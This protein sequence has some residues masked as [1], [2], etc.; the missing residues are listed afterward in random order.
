MMQSY[1]EIMS[2]QREQE[3]ILLQ[4]QAVEEKQELLAEEQAANPSEPS[5]V[6]YFYNADYDNIS[7][8]STTYTIHLTKNEVKRIQHILK[9]TWFD[10]ITPDFL[11]TDSLSM[12]D[13]HLSTI[14]ETESDELIKSS[15]EN[16][17][18]T[19]SESEDLSKDLSDIE[20]ECNVPVC[21]DFTTVSNPL[22]DVDNDFSSSDDKSFSDEDVPKENFKNF[23]NPLSDEEIISTKIDP[24]HF[25]AESDLIESLLNRDTLIISSPKFDSLLEEFSGELA[26]IDLIPPRINEADFDPEEDIH[27]VN[28]LL[29]DNSSPRPPKEFNYEYSDAIIE[30][31]SP[32]PIPVEDSDS[33]MEKI[34]LFLT[35]DDSMPSGIE[36]D[37][38]ESEGDILFLEEL[39]SNDSPSLPENESFHFDVPS[40]PRPPARPP[41]EPPDVEICFDFKPDA[42]VV[43]NKV[44]GDISEYYVLMPNLLP[45][46][47]TLCPVFDLLLLFSSENEDKVFN[48]GR[49]GKIEEEVYVCQPP[50]FEDPDF[51]NKVYKVEK[52]LYG[53]HQA[54]KAWY[55]TLS[56]YLLG[57]GFQRGKIDK[58]LFIRRDKGDILLVQ[59]YVD[60]II[61]GSTKKSL[62]IE[63][64][65]MMHKKFQM[66]STVEL[67]FFLRLQVKQKEDVIFISQDKYVTE[68]LKKFG[69]TD[70]KT[71]S[72]P[73]ETQKALLKD[74]DGE[75]VD[76]HLY[77][78]MI[79]SLMYLTSSRP[80]IMFAVCACA[81]YQVNPKVSH[82]HAVKR[83]F[84]YLK[85]QPKLG[86]WYP[87]DSPFDLVAYTHSD[88][89]RA[90]LDR[91]F[92]TGCCQSLGCRL[93]SWQC[94]KQTVVFNSTTE[95]EYVVASSCC[96]QVLWIQNQLLDYSSKTTAWNEFSSTMASAIIC[97]ATNQKFN[98]LKYIFDNMVK[99]L[100]NVSSKFLMYLRFVQV[101][102]DKQLEG[103]QSHKRIYDA[104]SHTKKI[105]GNMKM[106]KKKKGEGSANPTDPHHTPTIIQPSTSQPQKKQRS[107]RLKRKDTKV[108]QLSGPITN[109]A[110]EAV[111]EEMDD[112]WGERR[113][114]PTREVAD[115]DADVGINYESCCKVPVKPVS[116]ATTTTTVITNDEITLAKALAELKSAKL[117]TTTAATIITTEHKTQ[118]KKACKATAEEEEEEEERLAREKAQQIKEVNIVWDDV[119]ARVKA[120]NQLAKDLQR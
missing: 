25:N 5:P 54:P 27:L 99:N 33:L 104:P 22:F 56:T 91:K 109:V 19:P 87:K 63:F 117:P 44:V 66:S 49:N 106:L 62:C 47:P 40:S 35:L 93:I 3:A 29:Y 8:P 16:L 57:N 1:C 113:M 34:D 110:D 88:Y 107:R 11:I 103:M 84:R 15:V 51:P 105:F 18:P 10:V 92:I 21:D 32:S 65:K 75:E 55:E 86:L 114:H 60:D 6:S 42:G 24:H 17:V 38:Y 52:A 13:E 89:A 83:I 7:T 73:M 30:S 85:G 59:V 12:G 37:D 90:S 68:I 76:V 96:G 53:L 98:F 115:I 81:R 74:E 4:E 118:S 70:V 79:G 39:L 46:Q 14:S 61:F 78:S 26:H 72:T 36:N 69:F 97:L 95:A 108:P 20:S 58:T 67:T 101:F 112:I 71:A 2:Q 116:A 48:P 102:L 100:E 94:K 31:F 43:T 50:G 9:R 120:D 45:T 80:D 28:K 119:Q 64:E 77:R 23:S 41:P 82:L 111:N